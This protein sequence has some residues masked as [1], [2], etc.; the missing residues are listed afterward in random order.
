MIWRRS[1]RTENS[2][3]KIGKIPAIRRTKRIYILATLCSV[4]TIRRWGSHADR[5]M[6]RRRGATTWYKWGGGRER[7]K[8]QTELVMRSRCCGSKG[9]TISTAASF[10]RTTSRHWLFSNLWRLFVTR[11]TDHQLILCAW[12]VHWFREVWLVWYS[13][14][15]G[16]E[17]SVFVR[18]RYC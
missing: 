17:S 10:Y 15:E 5:K 1:I 9:L 2:G 3:K 13:C 16:L 14:F 11:L 6:P 18:S 7:T 12:S 8:P 4:V